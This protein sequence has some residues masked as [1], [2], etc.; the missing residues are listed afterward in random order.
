MTALRLV[1]DVQLSESDGRDPISWKDRRSPFILLGAEPEYAHGVEE[2]RELP[3]RAEHGEGPRLLAWAG[4]H[5]TRLSA[6][7]AATR[8]SPVRCG[9]RCG[10]EDRSRSPISPS[11]R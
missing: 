5:R 3:E 11:A 9:I 6:A 7:I 1:S 8:C 4:A 2:K 10:A